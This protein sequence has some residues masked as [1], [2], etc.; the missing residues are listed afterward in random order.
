MCLYCCLKMLGQAPNEMK[1]GILGDVFPDLDQTIT[2]LLNS[3]T[4]IGLKHNIP[5]ELELGQ[6]TIEASH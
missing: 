3:V 2:E 5:E 1:D 6:A 4:V